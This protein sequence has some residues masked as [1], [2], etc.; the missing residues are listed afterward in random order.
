MANTG[1]LVREKLFQKRKTEGHA[2][3][4]EQAPAASSAPVQ[5]SQPSRPKLKPSLRVFKGK[6]D[7]EKDKGHEKEKE[8]KKEKNQ[9]SGK[10]KMETVASREVLFDVDFENV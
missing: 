9:E 7:K 1:A 5:P 2:E 10:A 3:I 4:T 8:F 6:K